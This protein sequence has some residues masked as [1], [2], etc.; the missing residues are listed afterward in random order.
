MN[1]TC[2][3]PKHLNYALFVQLLQKIDLT[4]WPI[5]DEIVFGN[6]TLSKKVAVILPTVRKFVIL[7]SVNSGL[8]LLSTY[9]LHPFDN[10]PMMEATVTCWLDVNTPILRHS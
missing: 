6:I 5:Q 10:L 9:E 8:L 4:P 7:T 3:N 1:V 2:T